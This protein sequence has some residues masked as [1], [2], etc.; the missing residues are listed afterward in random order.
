MSVFGYRLFLLSDATVGVE[1]P[2]TF[3]E[4]IVTR[5]ALRSFETRL[6]NCLLTRDFIAACAALKISG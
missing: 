4:W 1:F 3:Q 6:G 2:D 5:A